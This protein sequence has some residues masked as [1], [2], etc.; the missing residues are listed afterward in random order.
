[1]AALEVKL[2]R[3]DGVYAP[4][5]R[6]TGTVSWSLAEVPGSLELC[7]FWSTEG[8]GTQDTRIVIREQV[9][10]PHLSGRRA[11]DLPL[12]VGPLS[13]AGSLVSLQWRLE[14]IA[15]GS[16]AHAHAEV[17]LSHTGGTLQLGEP[18][19]EDETEPLKLRKLKEK[20]QAG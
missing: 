15:D 13:F 18:E 2:D 4:G 3:A 19:E 8:K 17:V 12:P 14:V 5:E 10:A 7:L 20:L 6:L 9:D 16:D 1:M 11:F